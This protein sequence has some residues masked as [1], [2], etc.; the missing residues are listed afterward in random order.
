MTQ[1]ARFDGTDGYI[2]DPGLSSVVNAAIA[3]RRPLLVKGEPGTGKT[4]LAHA[5]ADS[6]GMPLVSWHVKSTTKATD[7]LYHY[8]VVQRLNDSRF[9]DAD[10][11]DIRK[12]IDLGVLG[13][14]FTA[15]S[16]VVLL[17]DEIDKADLE[18]PNDLLRELDEM[19]F[20]IRELDETV[21]AVNR[22]VVIITSNAEKELPDAFLRR[23]VFHFIE[24]PDRERM[25]AIVKVHH[26]GLA[27]DLLT[28]AM[29]R[30]FAFRKVQGLRKPPSTSE[31]V[32]WLTV[33]IHSG[34]SPEDVK[35]GDPFL[36]VLFKQ[37]ADLDKIRNPRR[38]AY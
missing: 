26:P 37:E 31:L 10:V 18:F 29:D 15:E 9:G 28:A 16:P 24:F 21:K 3:L 22:P 4:L 8:D 19:A 20:H 30:F 1:F 25:E 5:V 6:L 12:Y 23:C 2:S 36:G 17:I 32:D 33:L 14:A 27:D 11:S 34:L 13:K 35:D 7:G 38:R